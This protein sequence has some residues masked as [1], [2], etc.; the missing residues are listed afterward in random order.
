MK[1]QLLSKFEPAGDQPQAIAKLTKNLQ[2]NKKYQ[3]LLGI[4]GSGKTF[5]MA[6]IIQN[7]QKPTLVI[8]HNKTLAAQLA[9]EFREFFPKNA[10]H[11]FVSYY[12][13]Y[14]PE[15][16]IPQTDSYIEKKTKI[17][18]E[19]ERLRHA[20]TQSLLS[21]SD[22]IITASV[23]CIYGLGSPED[24][25]KMT[26][27]FKIGAKKLSLKEILIQLI[28]IQYQR[29]DYEFSRRSFR[30]RGDSLEIH[31]SSADEIIKI[32]FFGDEIEKI[33]R[34]DLLTHRKIEELK[35]V[36]IFPAKH[37][38]VSEKRMLD[39]FPAI[40]EE[41]KTRINY[42]KKKKKLLEAQRIQQKT[43]FDLEMLEQTGYCNGVENYS[44]YLTGRAP[45]QPPYT[46]IDY[47][48]KNFLLFIDES[49]MTIPQING[50]YAGDFSRKS[51]LI[52]YGFRLPSALDNRPLKFNEFEKKLKQAIFVSAT[53]GAY[54]MKKSQIIEQL[55]RPTGLLDPVIEIR[56]IKN[57]I[58]D[59]IKE[60]QKRVQKKQRVLI[61]TLTKKMAENLS[62][63]L[64]EK[65]IKV[66]YLHSEIETLDRLETLKKL[67]QG[68]YDVIVGINLL[69]EGLDLP[70]VS[71]VIILDADKEGFL[72]SKTSLIQTMGRAA[73][74]QEG[75]VIM[76]A[77][78][79]TQSMQGAM[80]ETERRRKTQIAFNKK[81]NITPRSITKKIK[82]I[83]PELTKI[84][85]E[86]FNFDKLP[87]EEL[88]Y[89]I[90]NL[91]SAMELCAQNL[92]FEQAAKI[93]DEIKILEHSLKR[94]K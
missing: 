40:K 63:F 42:F 62:A 51:T 52:E 21:Q 82:D 84:K 54:E 60:I 57:Q 83:F 15:S 31:P 38:L 91:E 14:Q 28:K 76:Y 74:H 55:V 44:R 90:E 92:E 86:K 36:S 50:M 10:V 89:M 1:F 59:L 88:K 61:T 43:N 46:L 34:I 11:Y 19:I 53:P 58:Q 41:L 71:L 6:N 22:V 4:T 29:N 48:P 24:Y 32:D 18:A 13:Y 7:L 2:N 70:E 35:E 75:K 64:K 78:I 68:K 39:F 93:R 26:E 80:Q 73:R 69:R 8:S 49:H 33:T 16:Y 17:N 94:K 20:A 56:P 30:L 23:S 3:T 65:N 85:K 12:D 27:E 77:D 66:H 45:G 67:R 25:A 5:T 37:W 47:F 79:I 87:K 81:H 72:R 9:G